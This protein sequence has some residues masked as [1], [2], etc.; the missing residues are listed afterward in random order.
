MYTIYEIPGVKVGCDEHWPYRAKEQKVKPEDCKILQQGTDIVQISI[1]ELWWQI[2]LGYPIDNR[3]YWKVVEAN[4][5]VDR[6]KRAQGGKIGG[7]IVGAKHVESGHW[8]SIKSE[9]QYV[10]SQIERTC[11]YCGKTGKGNP[12]KSYHINNQ[13]CINKK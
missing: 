1:D 2:E 10:S 11:P 12:F 13:K 6:E 3:P 4:R 7:K 5:K 8:Q 9:G